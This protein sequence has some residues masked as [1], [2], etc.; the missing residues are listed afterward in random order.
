[1]KK[2]LWILG[3]LLG[4]YFIARA[5][6]W[7]F[8]VDAGDPSTYAGDWGGPTLLGAAAVHCGPGV[9]SAL[10][11]VGAIVRGRLTA[12]GLSGSSRPTNDRI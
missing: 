8:S 4:L 12:R 2:T 5:I 3:T 1:M 6:S 9:V 11:L 10:V 7:P